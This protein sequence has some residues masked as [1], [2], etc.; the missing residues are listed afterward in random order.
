[1]TEE[2]CKRLYQHYLSVDRAD[3]AEDLLKYYPHFKD[4]KPKKPEPKEEKKPEPEPKGKK[5]DGKK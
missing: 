1:M 5:K 3:A 4:E 2:N